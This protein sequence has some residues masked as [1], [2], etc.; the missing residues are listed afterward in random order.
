MAIAHVGMRA[1]ASD[2]KNFIL[3]VDELG[4]ETQSSRRGGDEDVRHT[5]MVFIRRYTRYTR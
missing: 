2:E 1:R 5:T 3:V 4:L